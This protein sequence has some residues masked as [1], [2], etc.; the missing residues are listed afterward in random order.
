[1]LYALHGIPILFQSSDP[2][3]VK[4]WQ[5]QWASFAV[6]KLPSAAA[7]IAIHLSITPLPPPPD[8]PPVSASPLVAYYRQ[9]DHLVVYGPRW[10][11][12]DVDLAGQR[13]TGYLTEACLAG[14]GVFEDVIMMALAPLLRRR[15]FYTLHAFAAAHDRQA[16]LLVGD[17]GAGK[18]TTGLALLMAGYRLCANDSPLLH[19]GADGSVRVMAYPGLISLYPQ[20][21]RW[22]PALQERLAVIPSGQKDGKIAFALEEVWPEAWAYEAQPGAVFFPRVVAGLTASVLRPLDR[23]QAL[24]RLATNA[25]EQWDTTSIPGHLQ[26]LR[27]LVETCPTYELALAPDVERLPALITAAL[28]PT[29]AQEVL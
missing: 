27:R 24:R 16:V 5:R 21:L 8:I 14:H 17:I 22:F 26:L 20:S 11:R 3:L 4:R 13:L 12:C 29:T 2:P 1:M 28:A 15:G 7:P 18:T 23:F 25:I 6:D 9:G 10:G 19:A